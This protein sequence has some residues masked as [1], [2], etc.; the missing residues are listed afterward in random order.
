MRRRMQEYS[1]RCGSYS[2]RTLGADQ[3]PTAWE[4]DAEIEVYHLV[5]YYIG[6]DI[7]LAQAARHKRIFTA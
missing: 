6:N 5:E 7:L 4:M 2:C 1:Y 3:I